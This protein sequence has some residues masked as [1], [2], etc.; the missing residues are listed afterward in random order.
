VTTI[1]VIYED[2]R[3]L[4][5]DK[6]PGILSIPGRDRKEK[7]VVELLRSGRRGE[8]SR[9]SLFVVHRIDRETSGILL[10]AKTEDAHRVA[11]G[12]FR[13]HSVRKE[14]LAFAEGSPRLPAFRV[15]VPIEEK[16]S[17]S[18]VQ[19]VERFTGAFLARVRIATGRRHQ[20]RI[21]LQHEGFPILGDSKYGG[22]KKFSGI[23][24]DRVALHA[25]LLALPAEEGFP[26]AEIRAPWPP[27]FARWHEALRSLPKAEAK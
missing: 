3:F 8:S 4:V 24:V 27:D 22:R 19:V 20:I 15:N 23:A 6:P 14:Y 10:F 13:D 9:P 26:A 21:H 17:L 7:S 25:E 1:P 2:A 5:V 11:N 12:W 18:Q 16:A